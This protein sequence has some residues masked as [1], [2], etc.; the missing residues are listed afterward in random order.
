[1]ATNI[2]Q[3]LVP[4]DPADMTDAPVIEIEIENPDDVKDRRH[5]D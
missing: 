1:M 4:F 3:A 2:D 5:G